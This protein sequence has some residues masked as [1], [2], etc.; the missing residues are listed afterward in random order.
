MPSQP[1]LPPDFWDDPELP[2]NS[3]SRRRLPRRVRGVLKALLVF[4]L[5]LIALHTAAD[6]YLLSRWKQLQKEHAAVKPA[7]SPAQPL[8]NAVPLYMKAA[9]LLPEA[10]AEA[11]AGVRKLIEEGFAGPLPL[12]SPEEIRGLQAWT[13]SSP[14]VWE[15]IV[16]A[17]SKPGFVLSPP[18]ELT[19]PTHSDQL[20]NFRRIWHYLLARAAVLSASG[21]GG[22]ACDMLAIASQISLHLMKAPLVIDGFFAQ[23]IAAGTLSTA[24]ITLEQAGLPATCRHVLLQF[25]RTLRDPQWLADQLSLERDFMLEEARVSNV[26]WNQRLFRPWVL[27]VLLNTDKHWA[28]GLAAF[29]LPNAADSVQALEAIEEADRNGG[30]W[31]F[32]L[33]PH[34]SGTKDNQRRFAQRCMLMEV[35]LLEIAHR[36]SHG[37]YFANLDELGVTEKSLPESIDVKADANGFTLTIDPAVEPGQPAPVIMWRD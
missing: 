8:E 18:M 34:F 29:G 28:R 6:Q 3:P 30:W 16:E 24:R 21:Q 20:Q 33:A 2:E 35:C 5:A 15:V 32:H 4:F 37:A 26:D 10:P 11:M 31:N 27:F 36:E 12:L 22:E 17:S 19:P 1:S 14:G 13:D 9:E 7:V 23:A 25:S